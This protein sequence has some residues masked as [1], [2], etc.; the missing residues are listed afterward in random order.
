PP[1]SAA[2]LPAAAPPAAPP[3]GAATGRAPASAAAAASAPAE[4]PDPTAPEPSRVATTGEAGT[5]PIP[6][7]T[8][9]PVGAPDRET[10]TAPGT[11]DSARYTTGSPPADR[12]PVCLP[13]PA[14]A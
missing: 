14:R 2:R 10:A 13:G 12:G 11:L 5:N 1:A 7:A 3:D 4:R 6:G 9:G 8:P